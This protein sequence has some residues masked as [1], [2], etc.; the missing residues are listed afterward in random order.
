MSASS[1]A[2][3]Q[4]RGSRVAAYILMTA[5]NC[6][7][8]CDKRVL[9][10]AIPLSLA[11]LSFTILTLSYVLRRTFKILR[12]RRRRSKLIGVPSSRPK[13]SHGGG[14]SYGTSSDGNGHHD[15][16]ERPHGSTGSTTPEGQQPLPVLI[17]ETEAEHEV[18]DSHDL[19]LEAE[20]AVIR[21]AV[22]D[23]GIVWPGAFKALGLLKERENHHLKPKVHGSKYL[24][25]PNDGR[26][27]ASDSWIQWWRSSHNLR[28]TITKKN[29][30]KRR[31]SFAKTIRKI[32]THGKK[33]FVQSLL[34]WALV[35]LLFIKYALADRR[36]SY[37]G[38]V[39]VP[40]F[41]WVSGMARR[42]YFV[43]T[44]TSVCGS[45]EARQRTCALLSY[46]ADAT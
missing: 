26:D 21:Q 25:V 22:K 38:W 45:V 36:V 5:V 17:I 19:M 44:C 24:Q 12:R 14:P 7:C 8:D 34:A 31:R 37:R 10:G 13:Y 30:Y 28:T 27:H 33:D 41:I 2:P 20:N 32:T 16:D 39:L 15:D 42:S 43:Q 1:Q 40:A 23:Q 6:D 35:A 4:S 46:I 3:E 11:C 18:N 9:D 29:F